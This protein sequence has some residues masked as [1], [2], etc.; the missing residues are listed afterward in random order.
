[1]VIPNTAPSS[2]LQITQLERDSSSII[3]DVDTTMKI[4]TQTAKKSYIAARYM[5][6]WSCRGR[7]HFAEA[8][9]DGKALELADGR[10]FD[11]L[12]VD[13]RGKLWSFV[14]GRLKEGHLPLGKP[15]CGLARLA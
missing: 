7:A 14:E 9:G 2:M 12:V 5:A 13:A 11:T 3:T 4:F 10:P 15:V 6:P 1:M 8:I